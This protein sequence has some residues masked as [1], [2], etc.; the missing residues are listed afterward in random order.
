ML[1]KCKLTWA[2][3]N[4]SAIHASRQV[5]EGRKQHRKHV[6]DYVVQVI[7]AVRALSKAAFCWK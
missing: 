7:S 2:T 3:P 4:N 6:R 5:Q 1:Q